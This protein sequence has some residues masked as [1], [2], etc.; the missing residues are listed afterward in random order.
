MFKVR[1]GYRTIKTAVGT[2][3][4]VWLARAL[5]LDSY[6]LAGIITMLGI[7]PT[8]KRSIS[9]AVARVFL[10]FIAVV[11][12]GLLFTVIGYHI[13]ALILFFLLFI[14]LSVWLKLGEGLVIAAVLI[15]HVF[16][17]EQLTW[18]IFVNEMLL[19]I[20]GCF[21]ALTFNVFM[22]DMSGKLQGYQQ[23]IEA[24]YAAILRQ[25]A[26]RVRTGNRGEGDANDLTAELESARELLRDAK[27]VAQL[28]KENDFFLRKRNCQED[29][30][31]YLDIRRQQFYELERMVNILQ[32]I[33]DSVPNSELVAAFIDKVAARAEAA[34]DGGRSVRGA[35]S[36][37]ADEERLTSKGKSPTKDEELSAPCGE[38]MEAFADLYDHFRQ[39]ELPVTREEFELRSS[40][41]H[42]LRVTS[43]YLRW[44]HLL[45]ETGEGA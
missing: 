17:Y 33:H 36:S 27:R 32:T 19:V 15:L 23:K 44:E 10:G 26:D 29:Y 6:T 25:V 31:D 9:G 22:P 42:L 11:G 20:V 30:C 45:G 24:M 34:A 16:T 13:P 3:V 8:L 4:A 12:S 7:Q 40:L 18:E 43:H 1:I 5:E 39:G 38:L 2:G 21:V 37:A 41:F 14:P 28:D 35:E